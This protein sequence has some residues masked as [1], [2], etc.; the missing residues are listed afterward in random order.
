MEESQLETRTQND[1]TGG[2]D[3]EVVDEAV[4]QERQNLQEIYKRIRHEKQT[5][6]KVLTVAEVKR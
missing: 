4:K 3:V 6:G 1:N 5:T 2:N